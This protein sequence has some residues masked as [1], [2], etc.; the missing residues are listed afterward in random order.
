[1]AHTRRAFL[2]SWS[3]PLLGGGY[4]GAV[5]PPQRRR[6]LALQI[7]NQAARTASETPLPDH[8][9]NGDERLYPNYIAGFSKGLPH[10]AHGEVDPK[11]YRKMLAALASG[12]WSDFEAIPSGCPDPKR[13]RRLSNPE[14]GLAFSLIGPDSHALAS[15]PPPRLDGA[16][17]AAEAVELYWM[18]LARDVPF[19]QYAENPI[20]RAAAEELTRLHGFNGSRA[21]GQVTAANLFRGFTSADVTG[22]YVSQF[23]LKPLSFGA[24]TIDPRIQPAMAGTDYLTDFDSWLAIRNGC[25]PAAPVQYAHGSRL[26]TT[27]RDLSRW[28]QEDMVYQAYLNAA[29]LIL[30]S[31][32]PVMINPSA[33]AFSALNP[34]NSSR[35][36]AGFGTFGAPFVV[37]LV[38][39]AAAIALEVVWYQKWFVHRRLRPE[40]YGGLLHQRKVARRDY[41]IHQNAADSAAVARVFAQYG[42]HLLPQAFPEAAPLHP[43]YGA[44]HAAVA[45]AC[46]TVLKALFD[47]AAPFP[48]PVAPVATGLW[49][50]PYRGADAGRMTVGGELNKLAGNM[51]MARSFAGIHWRTDNLSAMLLG[52]NVALGMLKEI[53]LTCYEDFQGFRFTRFDGTP[54]AIPDDS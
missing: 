8:P 25:Q 49:T 11:A 22:P 33:V 35:M 20:T 41:P 37:C 32:D 46:V 13:Q 24:Q 51:S 16:E 23:L 10:D 21:D 18:A 45:G 30:R 27:G 15:P 9:T 36:Q 14:L 6:A 7:R 2:G 4:D 40:D 47:E 3:M 53:K 17:Q 29:T 48:N 28:V 34:Y 1:M 52:E 12:K 43:S 26:V 38:A 31:T 42:T 54:I 39:E 19:A 44:G 50:E 5:G